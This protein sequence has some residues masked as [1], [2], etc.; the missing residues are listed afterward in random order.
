VNGQD[1]NTVHFPLSIYCCVHPQL[2]FA[3]STVQSAFEWKSYDHWIADR[4][5]WSIWEHK[6]FEVDSK[7]SIHETSFCC[8]SISISCMLHFYYCYNTDKVKLQII[9][10]SPLLFIWNVNDT[11]SHFGIEQKGH[12][13]TYTINVYRKFVPISLVF[14]DVI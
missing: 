6:K 3:C 11:F 12:I 14:W 9:P 1:D 13:R 5:V 10:C 4:K 2:P 8:L 7:G